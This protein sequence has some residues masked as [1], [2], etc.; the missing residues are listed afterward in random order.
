MKENSPTSE[1]SYL[2][3]QHVS[4]SQF[5]FEAFVLP[6]FLKT[7]NKIGTITAITSINKIPTSLTILSIIP[8]IIG[9]Y[10]V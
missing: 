4:S 5:G 2:L 8:L 10:Y 7:K 9:Y 6:F 3:H 1:F